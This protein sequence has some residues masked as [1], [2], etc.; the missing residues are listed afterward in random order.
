MKTQSVSC[1]KRA[2]LLLLSVLLLGS[3]AQVA[4]EEVV[5]DFEQVAIRLDPNDDE[6]IN[7][8]EVYEEQGV[9][10]KLARQ[11]EKSKAKGRI[12][13]FPHIS[14]GRKGILNA[15]ANEQEIPVQ[16]RFPQAVSAV[17]IGFWGSTGASALLEAFDADGQR[18]ARDELPV[19]PGRTKPEDPIPM[20][21]LSVKADSIA[22]VEFS[23]PRAGEYLAADEIRFI[24][25]GNQLEKR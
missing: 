5:I 25:A 6:K 10:F 14:S 24:T 16:V 9:Q 13:F 11:P 19:V 1:A 4:G 15:M 18:V 8:M 2:S 23:G 3:S 20:F 21:Q 12:M 22:Y 7:R 17:T